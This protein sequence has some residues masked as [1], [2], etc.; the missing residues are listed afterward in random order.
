MHRR[1]PTA[2]GDQLVLFR[3]TLPL[4]QWGKLPPDTREDVTTLLVELLRGAS[5]E[6]EQ[7]RT[8]PEEGER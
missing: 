8:A 2:M 4:I 3:P 1:R 7:D 6:Q 5:A